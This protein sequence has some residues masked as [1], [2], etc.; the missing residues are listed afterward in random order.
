M[1]WFRRGDDA[2]AADP[3]AERREFERIRMILGVVCRQRGEDFNI[4]TDDVSLGGIRFISQHAVYPNED[5]TLFL[6]LNPEQRPVSIRGQ[7]AWVRAEGEH[8][9]VGGIAFEDVPEGTAHDWA[10]FIERNRTPAA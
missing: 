9:Y 4:F 5:A 3:G 8:Q 10:E 2:E 7:V 6:S 1:K